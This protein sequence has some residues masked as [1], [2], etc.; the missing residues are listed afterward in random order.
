[1]RFITIF[2]SKNKINGSCEIEPKLLWDG[3][4][5]QYAE[6]VAFGDNS[7]WVCYYVAI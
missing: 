7:L 4:P 3:R 2:F 1:M 6:T 5:K